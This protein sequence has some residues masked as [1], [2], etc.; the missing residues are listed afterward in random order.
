MEMIT[1][2]AKPSTSKTERDIIVYNLRLLE[3]KLWLLLHANAVQKNFD[4]SH[5]ELKKA[6]SF[7]RWSAENVFSTL[8]VLYD[9]TDTLLLESALT[10]SSNIV[11]S[12]KSTLE[13]HSVLES[14]F[15]T[16]M[17]SSTIIDWKTLKSLVLKITPGCIV[18]ESLNR[19]G[20]TV[21]APIAVKRFD[22][23]VSLL[24]N[25]QTLSVTEDA[26]SQTKDLLSGDN[27]SPSLEPITVA[28]KPL[29]GTVAANVLDYGTGGMNIDTCRVPMDAADY[30]YLSKQVDAIRDRGGIMDNSWSNCSDLSGANPANPLGRWPANFIHDGSQ[31]V[32]DL[33]PGAS[34]TSDSAARFFYCSKAGKKDRDLD[35]H[36]NIHPTVKPV[37]LMR[38]L[39][40]LVTQ[41][42][43]TVLDPFMGSGTTGK[44]AMLDGFEFIGCEMDEQYY[45]IAEARIRHALER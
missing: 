18:A 38:Y 40:R 12:W 21:N 36:G 10:S 37:D 14:T 28:R 11:S 25:I 33:F 29:V 20:S 42:G 24:K 45:K 34:K 2:A 16:G 31:E 6:L 19:V 43:G 1:V 3:E 44:A 35:E 22:A 17:E 23:Y 8:G 5:P 9:L 30:E 7:V 27:I 32:L 41:H 13:E 26:M 39:C 15:T 4:A